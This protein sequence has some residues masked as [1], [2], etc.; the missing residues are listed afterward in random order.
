MSVLWWCD[1]S[2][3]DERA[4]RRGRRQGASARLGR[5]LC[6][7]RGKIGVGTTRMR[8]RRD[9]QLPV[10]TYETVPGVPSVSILRFG[11]EPSLGG[12]P[13]DAHSHDFLVLAYFEWDGGSLR[14]GEREWQ[15]EAGD[16]YLLA[17]GEV[18]DPGGLE[19]AKG[20][21][22]FFPPEVLGSQAPGTFLSWRAHPLL[23]P[24]V[25]G[26]A[27][28]AQ[29]LKVP[30]EERAS[31]SEHL[32]ALDLEL[33]QRQDGYREAVLAHLTLLLVD[34]SRLAADVVGDFR[35]KDEPLL[36]EV[37]SFIEDHYYEP[38]S[39]RDVARAVSLSRGHLTTVVRRKTGRTVQEW[40]AERRMAEARRLLVE[41]DLTVEDVGR[42][43]GYGEPSY[44][45]R[46]F[47]RAH[48][49]TPL[50]WRRAGR[51]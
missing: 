17:P 4:V 3:F 7:G 45:V 13:P 19:D 34:L 24:F 18:A 14:L 2:T 46:S 6:T 50:N 37:F 29:R 5:A 28:G 11:R 36:A 21:A 48:G 8:V 31:W 33:R 47:R 12:L 23:F 26:A 39:L 51:P 22:V 10:Y 9:D 40:I 49:S 27:G 16:V 44:F 35:L 43:V 38:I 20:W 42:R 32:S 30:P 1:E 25:R 15:I 41:T